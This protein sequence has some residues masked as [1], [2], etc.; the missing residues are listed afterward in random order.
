MVANFVNTTLLRKTLQGADTI[1][2]TAALDA[3][4]VGMVPDHEFE[5]VKV[6]GTRLLVKAA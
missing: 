6:K 5:W 2:H 3:P 4:Y 1:I